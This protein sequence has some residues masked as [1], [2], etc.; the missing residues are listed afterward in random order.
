[1]ERLA[2]KICSAAMLAAFALNA[3]AASIEAFDN[4]TVQP[5]GPRS[6]TSGK[7]FFN[8]EGSDNGSFASYGV[9]RF[10]A[11]AIRQALDASFG[12]GLWVIDTIHL[13]VT[14]SNASFTSDG[15]VSIHF[16]GDDATSIASGTSPLA[17][18]FAG[19]FADA[20]MV[21]S[22][23]FTEVSSGATESHLLWMR[24]SANT[25]GGDAFRNDLLTTN[26][27]TLALVDDSSSVAATYAGFSNSTYA[28][29][30][31]VVM[32]AP[33]PEPES[34]VLMLAGLGL[35]LLARHRKAVAS[36]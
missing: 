27:T 34:V 2:R 16:T 14:Q 1:M 15:P 13:Q 32:A 5:G 6:G 4:A 21:S 26:V 7:S 18:P 24:G 23:V 20:Q 19:D 30:T 33:V 35:I 29:P 36:V 9:A 17:H 8:I 28:G 11:A 3:N 22:Y 31:L 12:A 10:D 25:A